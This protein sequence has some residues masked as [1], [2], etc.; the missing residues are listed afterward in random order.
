MCICLLHFIYY[1]VSAKLGT[2]VAS[3]LDRVIETIPPPKVDRN[4]TFRALLFDC[5]FD[6]YRG[7][8]NLIYLLNGK[9]EVGQDIQSLT[10][11]KVYP[12]KS[13]SVLRPAEVEVNSM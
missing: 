10:T 7:A 3:V 9:L 1:Q 11:K 5:W 12:I 6:R 8:L 13:I 4:S 2:G